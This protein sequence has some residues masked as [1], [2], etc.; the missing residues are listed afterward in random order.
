MG[1][2]RYPRCWKMK[3]GFGVNVRFRLAGLKDGMVKGREVGCEKGGKP[4]IL[5]EA[6]ALLPSQRGSQ[7][8]SAVT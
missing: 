3:M 2:V 4:N 5:G 8:V 6:A 1:S 7:N